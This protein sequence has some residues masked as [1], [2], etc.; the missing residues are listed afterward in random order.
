MEA[1]SENDSVAMC[2]GR[3]AINVVMRNSVIEPQ[4]RLHVLAC[5]LIAVIIFY[6]HDIAAK[7][8]HQNEIIKKQGQNINISLQNNRV[9]SLYDDTKL[10]AQEPGIV[11]L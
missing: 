4:T 10:Y 11:D 7:I 2:G 3:D 1:I 8:D 6:L 9:I 5:I